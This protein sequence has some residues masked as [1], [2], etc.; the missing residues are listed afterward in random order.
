VK[1]WLINSGRTSPVREVCVPT[2]LNE[3]CFVEPHWRVIAS[4]LETEAWFNDGQ[5]VGTGGILNPHPI[6]L[7]TGQFYYRFASSS[8]SR[9]AQR[10]GGWWLDYENFR[11]IR[12]FADKQR[13]SLRDAA[14]LMLALPHAW[15]RVDIL[16]RALLKEPLKAY[17]GEGKP[18]RGARTGLDKGSLWIPTQHV[19]VRQLYIP[20]LYIKGTRPR[21]QLFESA[22][23]WPA[24]MVPLRA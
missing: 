18:A 8:S 23:V 2:P 14:R 22:F 6:H 19:K 20:G 10:G 16:I 12:S 21:P 1:Y 3:H 24:Q 5:G 17:A 11:M 9:E 7:P 4:G 15:T 13:C